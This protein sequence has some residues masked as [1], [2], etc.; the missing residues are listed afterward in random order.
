M[1]DVRCEAVAGEGGGGFGCLLGAGFDEQVPAGRQPGGCLGGDASLDVEAVAAAVEGVA[2]FVD[3]CFGWQQV[4][5][6]GG[7]VGRVG[8]EDVDAAA[9]CGGQ[10]FVEVAVVDLS[11]GGF[12]VAAGAAE[13]RKSVV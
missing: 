6:V 5:C 7:H 10:G 13:D 12:E 1:A 9:Q 2:G 3:A 4:E 8:D 11:A